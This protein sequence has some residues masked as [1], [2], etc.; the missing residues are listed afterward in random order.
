M[1]AG[2]GT[3]VGKT[4]VSAILTL[5]FEGDYWKPIQCGEEEGSDTARLRQ[6]L[7]PSKHHVHAPAYCFNLPLSPHH[8]ARLNK[9]PIDP[10]AITPP[11]TDKP[12]IIEGIGGVLV[13]ITA[14]LLTLD[15]FATWNCQ[16]IV[17][18]RH[19]LGSINHTLLT[20]ASLKQRHIPILGLIF[21]GHPNPDTEAAIL[22]MSQLPLLGRLLPEPN[23]NQQTLQRYAAQWHPVFI[24]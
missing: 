6:W 10:H 24:S 19:Y 20:I 17:V 3:D 1:V 5:L 12:L 9:T 4:V 15:L 21:N 16:W 22:E 8:A 23:L 14:Q 11:E 18:S 7:G 2:I 13:P